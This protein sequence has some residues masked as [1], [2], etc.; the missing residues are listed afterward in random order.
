MGKLIT[1]DDLLSGI[2]GMSERE[3]LN[4]FEDFLKWIETAVVGEDG[5]VETPAYFIVPTI[6]AFAD[7]IEQPRAETHRWFREHP[8]ASLQMR[9]MSADTIAAGAMLKAYDARVTS[10]A[11]KNWCGWEEAPAKKGKTSKELA[12]EKKAEEKLDAYWAAKRR[13]TI[14]AV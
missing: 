8:T 4:K 9:E 5:K 10:F 12:D 14:K 3:V 7:Y 2:D 6:S 13:A 1:A 11:L